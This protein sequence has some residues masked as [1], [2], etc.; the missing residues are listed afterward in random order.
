[1]M[2][3]DGGSQASFPLSHISPAAQLVIDKV[4][5]IRESSLPNMNSTSPLRHHIN[6]R[7]RQRAE[8]SQQSEVENTNRDCILDETQR[9]QGH[10]AAAV[11]II[12]ES[13]NEDQHFDDS[14]EDSDGSIEDEV[15]GAI[16]GISK[17][18]KK[19]K[20][21]IR[22]ANTSMERALVRRNQ[23]PACRYD[24]VRVALIRFRELNGNTYVKR[25]FIVPKGS[26][27]WPEETWGI[28]LDLAVRK[29][30]E[31]TTYAD[32]LEDLR[33]LGF[34]FDSCRGGYGFNMLKSGK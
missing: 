30:R 12:S 9:E 20:V 24:L 10:Q 28:R 4:D 25:G 18:T 15:D 26:A 31:G 32:H 33:S 1:M 11:A 29:I 7:K 13:G 3:Y 2:P 23:S 17:K 22:S 27:D 8:E 14:A 34:S 21:G 19:S 5:S 16:E 6:N